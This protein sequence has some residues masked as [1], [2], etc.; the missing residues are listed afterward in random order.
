MR[1]KRRPRFAPPGLSRPRRADT[2]PLAATDSRARS[3]RQAWERDPWATPGGWIV[4]LAEA[5]HTVGVFARAVEVAVRRFV[6][7]LRRR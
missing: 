5:G 2:T 6:R 7:E 4:V 3:W 1:E